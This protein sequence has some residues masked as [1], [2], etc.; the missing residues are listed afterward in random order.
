LLLYSFNTRLIPSS[1]SSPLLKVAGKAWDEARTEA[2]SLQSSSPSDEKGW[3]WLA[4]LGIEPAQTGYRAVFE[5]EWT[6]LQ[7]IMEE[8]WEAMLSRFREDPTKGA[9]NIAKEVEGLNKGLNAVPPRTRVVEEGGRGERGAEAVLGLLCFPLVLLGQVRREGIY[10]IF[11]HY[12][13]RNI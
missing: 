2:L 8:E 11:F 5:G 4:M 3:S 9:A 10:M 12:V 7:T 1:L 6:R 13:F